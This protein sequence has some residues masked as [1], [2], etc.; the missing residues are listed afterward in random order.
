MPAIR[1]DRRGF[2]VAELLIVVAIIAVLVGVAIPV[3][4]NQAERAREATDLA[5]VRSAY[6]EVMNTAIV[7]DKAS[8]LYNTESQTFK[9][10]VHLKQAVRG[11]SMDEKQLMVGGIAR[12]SSGW[13]GVPSANGTA[14]V[15]YSLSTRQATI[16]WGGEDHI[17]RISAGEFLT[18]D[19]LQ[20]VLGKNYSHTVVNSNE[21]YA[22]GEGT[23]KITDFFNKQGINLAD[24]DATTWQM[25]VKDPSGGF[26]NVPAIYW[27]TIK[28][29]ETMVGEGTEVF[30]PVMGY[31][32]GKYDVYRAK[33]VKYNA[34][35]TNEDGTKKEYL[36]FSNNFAN[37][38]NEGSKATFQFENYEDAKAAYDKLLTAYNTHKT[39]RPQD[40]SS[41]K[42]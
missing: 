38:M 39:V 25:Y 40:I 22:Q 24:Y 4:N 11:W 16:K 8:S 41:N 18:K 34:G 31:R 15:S 2:T 30:V 19:T 21:S 1:A 42:L 5:N 9:K 7:E 36:S 10:E 32:D 28:L 37:V 35:Q 33:V 12:G 20:S 17:N 27:S 14:T 29:Q 23:Q 26:L 13:R 6:A 3:F